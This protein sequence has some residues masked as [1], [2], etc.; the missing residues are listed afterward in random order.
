LSSADVR[1]LAKRKAEAR[2]SASKEYD[3]RMVAAVQERWYRLLAGKNGPDPISPEGLGQVV[4]TFL[5]HVDGKISDLQ[6]VS[7]AVTE[8]LSFTCEAAILGAS[9]FGRWPE[10]MLQSF[11]KGAREITFTFHYMDPAAETQKR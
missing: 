11:P 6:T 7:S 5:L 4:V 10:K 9:G 3:E 2:N 1:P 8:S